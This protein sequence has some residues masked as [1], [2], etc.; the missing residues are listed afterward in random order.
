MS[1]PKRRRR[2]RN[3]IAIMYNALVTVACIVLVL[4]VFGIEITQSPPVGAFM[5]V[6]SKIMLEIMGRILAWLPDRHLRS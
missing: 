5:L 1:R 6:I 4:Y 3:R 2:K